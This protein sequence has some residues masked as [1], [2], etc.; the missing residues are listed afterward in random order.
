[1]SAPVQ[2]RDHCLAAPP[3]LGSARVVAIDGPSGSGKTTVAR[4]LARILPATIVHADELCPGWDGLPDVPGILAALLEPLAAGR[5]G[6]FREWDW[7]R[8]RPGADRTVEPAP[9]LI[10]EGLGAGASLLRG[11]TTTLVWLDADP[12]RRRLRAFERDGDYFRDQWAPWASAES[13]YFATEGLP[14]RAD[15]SFRTG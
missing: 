4:Q 2:I 1:V 8:E 12:E 7:L 13:A 11:Q 6:A 14:E 9:V 10:I 3:T 5:P 15:L